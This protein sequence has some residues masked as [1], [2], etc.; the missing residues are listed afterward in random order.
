MK[1]LFLDRDG[2]L[3]KLI[4]N[5]PPWEI[6]EV[7]L[8]PQAKII[9]KIAKSKNYIPIIVTNQPDA[10]RGSIDFKTLYKINSYISRKLGIGASY[11]CDH[12]YDGI[13]EC[14]KPKIGM[15]LEAQ[16]KYK[17]NLEES[18]LIGDR[19]KDIIAGNTAQCTTI[20]LSKEN[21][22]EA[23]YSVPNHQELTLLLKKLL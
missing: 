19:K 9:I 3:N 18:W 4:N 6:K 2:V 20:S 23:N 12:P 7:S 14:R 22:E 21:C 11:V 1:A 17:L 10:A 8:F 5:R 15:L 13:C 16:K